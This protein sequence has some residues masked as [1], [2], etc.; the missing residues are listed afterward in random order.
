MP[1]LQK[2]HLNRKTA[3]ARI[4]AS[5]ARTA[6]RPTLTLIEGG[7]QVDHGGFDPDQGARIAA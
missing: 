5:K 1:L 7:G 3:L 4:A 2:A 6:E